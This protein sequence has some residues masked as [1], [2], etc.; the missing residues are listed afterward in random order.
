[1]KVYPKIPRYD[2]PVV[3][4][5]FFEADDLLLVE[6]FDGSSF[7]FTLYDE[8]YANAYPEQVA[9][10]ADGDGSLVFGTRRQIRGSHRDSLDTIDGALHR[11]VRC[12]RNGI[13]PTVLRT[14]HEEFGCPVVVYAENMVYSTIDY[15][16]AEQAVPALVGF[17]LLPFDTIETMT[18]RG[19]PYEET[20]EGF[21][22]ASTTWDL[23][24]RLQVSTVAPEFAFVSAKRIDRPDPGFDPDTYTVPESS[25]ANVR[26]EG[27][28]VRSDER[29][30]RVK[31][32][33]EGFQERNHEQFGMQ[34]DDAETGA[35]YVVAKYCTSGRIRS[36]LRQLVIEEGREFEL[37]L[38]EEL[39]ERVV[40][41]IWAENWQELMTLD[42]SFTP[43]ELYPFVAQRCITELRSMQTNAELNDVAPTAIWTHLE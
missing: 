26:M 37:H 19:N 28:I 41:D 25:L 3:P 6:K 27:V 13:D 15:G 42:R 7:R 8:R 32:L 31:I 1:V 21:C 10:A 36:V 43:A 12:L 22:S 4:D 33:R 20:F 24:E 2:H 16:F 39:H 11:A 35:E 30:R 38:N 17:D 9:A 34:P 23:F 29:A 14:A 40:E 18:P 5:E